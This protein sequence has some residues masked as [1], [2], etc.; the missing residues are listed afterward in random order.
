M[1]MNTHFPPRPVLYAGWV[2]AIQSLIGIAYAILL[3]VREATGHRD[4][5]IVYESDNANTWVGYGTAVF[6][7]IVFGAV[8]AGALMMNRGKRWG[9]GPVIMLQILLLPIAY[10]MF[11]GGALLFSAV[12]GLTAI[13]A[14]AMLFSP[15]AVDW[16][17]RNY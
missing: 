1:N 4:A 17:A 6:F 8:L 7:L 14:L 10:Y 11:N 12:T 9:R 13:V 16:A 3:I 15:R 2:A 5:S